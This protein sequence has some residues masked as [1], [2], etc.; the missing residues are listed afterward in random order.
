[1]GPT[2]LEGAIESFMNLS[3]TE[4]ALAVAGTAAA[5]TIIVALLTVL[6]AYLAAK[7]ERRRDIYSQAVRSAVAW[8][9]MVYRLRR[10][11]K[12]QERELIDHFH[13]LQDQLAYHQAW[14][15]SDSRYMKRSYDKLVVGVKAKTEPLI[16]AAWA[17]PVRPVPGN[18]EPGDDH[19]DLSDLV[20]KFLTDVRSHLSPWVWR[21]AAVAWR[22]RKGATVGDRSQ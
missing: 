18:A 3:D 17:A 16:T 19:P 10:R 6:A 9:E 4:R 2:P 22:N 8:K 21:K 7:R 20:D 15:G 5:A 13:D 11:T 12:G 1:M 14:V